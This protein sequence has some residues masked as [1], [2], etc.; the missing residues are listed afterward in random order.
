MILCIDIGNTNIKVALFEGKEGCEHPAHVWR[1]SSDTR[2]TADEYKCVIAS[3]VAQVCP[4]ASIKSSAIS[5]VVP[6]L[7]PVFYSVCKSITGSDAFVMSADLPL[8]VRVS[9]EAKSEIGS[10][11]LCDAVEAYSRARSPCIICDAGTAMSFVAVSS[12][13]EI[14]GVAIA[15]GVNTAL[16]ALVGGTAQLYSVPLVVPPSSLGKNTTQALQSGVI[17]GYTHLVRGLLT[18]MKSDLAGSGEC[19][20]FATGG[21]SLPIF[22]GGVL[23][24]EIDP[25]ITICGLYRA[26]FGS[27]TGSRASD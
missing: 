6:A 3:L 20:T 2:R 16:S 24:D 9:G 4:I 18:Q 19:K 1:I 12:D 17:L 23:F 27:G 15:P 22:S 13:G 10:D 5:S 8:P 14:A 25:D 11:L 7:T 21:L 26:L